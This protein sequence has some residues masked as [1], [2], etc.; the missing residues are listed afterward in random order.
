MID[1]IGA[2]MDK[3]VDGSLRTGSSGLRPP[4][5]IPQPGGSRA[6]WAGVRVGAGITGTV[7]MVADSGSRSNAVIVAVLAVWAI[8]AVASLAAALVR[9]YRVRQ[10][11]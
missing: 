4:V 8:L 5:R 9:M 1:R 2:E 11:G 3:R 7:A 10:R 6:L